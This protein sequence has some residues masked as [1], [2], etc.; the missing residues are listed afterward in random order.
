MRERLKALLGQMRWSGMAAVLDEELDLAERQGT[1]VPEV[2]FRLLGAED[3]ARREKSL[4]YRLSQAHLPW[5][6]TLQSFPFARQPSVNKTQVMTLA[7]LEFLRRGE[8]VLLIG[9]P[10]TGKSGIAVGLLREACL[11]GYRARFYTAQALLDALYASLA[12]RSTVALL[13]QLC[14]MPLIAID[15]LGYLNLKP[16]QVN[17]FFRLMDQRYS[18]GLSTLITTNLDLPDWYELFQ[19]KPL[20]DALLDR[21]QHRCIILRLS[22]PSL[23]SEPGSAPTITAAASVAA[24]KRSASRSIAPTNESAAS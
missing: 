5:P 21:L 22:G 17:A 3:A 8:N 7:G 18:L 24:A 10:G 19:R 13:N 11:N 15:E 2:L 12:D 1:P 9:P 14:R 16:E 20:V 4:A 23:R 6:W